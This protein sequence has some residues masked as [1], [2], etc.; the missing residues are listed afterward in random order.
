[1]REDTQGLVTD[2]VARILGR[3][4]RSFAD[5]CHRHAEVFRDGL[6]V[7]APETR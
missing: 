1:M 7:R 4:P 2:D 5:W 3:A 6:G